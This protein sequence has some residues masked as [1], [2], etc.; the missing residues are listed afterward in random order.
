MVS[1]IDIEKKCNFAFDMKQKK[2]LDV[3]KQITTL[4]VLVVFITFSSGVM[5]TIHE[6]CKIHQHNCCEDHS[7][8][9][10]IITDSD[11]NLSESTSCEHDLD[12]NLKATLEHDHIKTDLNKCSNHAH[13]LI[14]TYII[15]ITDHFIIPDFNK[16]QIK[17]PVTLVLFANQ[18]FDV[19]DLDTLYYQI[20]TKKESPPLLVRSSKLFLDFT[21][22][23]I[24][25]A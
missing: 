16:D 7:H 20:D 25:Y 6:C 14:L 15:K 2:M 19:F 21:S 13:C 1:I 18:L 4:V 22:Q 23:R 11:I 10:L 24:Y 8:A 5:V 12:Q 3:V 17:V 9:E